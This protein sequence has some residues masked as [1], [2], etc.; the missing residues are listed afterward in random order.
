VAVALVVLHLR[1]DSDKLPMTG[2]GSGT[3]ELEPELIEPREPG[4]TEPPST[5]EP[6]IVPS[7]VADGKGDEE[8]GDAPGDG[9][10][11]RVGSVGGLY[12]GHRVELP[13]TYVNPQT[14][15]IAIDTV[16]VTATGTTAC[17]SRHLM[18]NQQPALHMLIPAGSSIASTVAVGMDK[19]APDA[20]QGVRFTVRVSVT[21]VKQ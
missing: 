19:T 18:P 21:A 11:V 20:C 17:P 6:E 12:P 13:V 10:G 7:D 16:N 3:V 1:G 5:P 2:Q 15:P 8:P 9:I 14:F 4:A